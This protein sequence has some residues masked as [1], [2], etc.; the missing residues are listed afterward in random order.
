ME[1]KMSWFDVKEFLFAI[2]VYNWCPRCGSKVE[3]SLNGYHRCSD[4]ECK[5]GK[6]T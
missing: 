6:M 2:S 3:Q 4:P 5:W 1:E